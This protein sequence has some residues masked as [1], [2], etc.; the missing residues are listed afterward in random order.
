MTP[1]FNFFLLFKTSMI[2]DYERVY[3]HFMPGS[4]DRRGILTINNEAG[5]NLV[6]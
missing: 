3:S 4:E 2:G 5:V 1:F 6:R